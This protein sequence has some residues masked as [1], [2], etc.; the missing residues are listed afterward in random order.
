MRSRALFLYKDK[1]FV[2][3]SRCFLCLFH[4]HPYASKDFVLQ[5]NSTLVTFT[6]CMPQAKTFVMFGNTL[7]GHNGQLNTTAPAV[8]NIHFF[9][10]TSCMPPP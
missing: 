10:N 6:L 5:K 3:I 1:F 2:L 8:K 4:L 9:L 7:V